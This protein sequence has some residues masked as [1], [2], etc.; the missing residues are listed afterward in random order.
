MKQENRRWTWLT[1]LYS[2]F[3]LVILG[4]TVLTLVGNPLKDTPTAPPSESEEEKYIYV[5]V[6][7]GE[8]STEAP[9]EESLWIVRE[10]EKKIGIFSEDGVLLDV[11]EVYTKTLPSAD[12][13]LLREGIFVRSRKELYSLMEDYGA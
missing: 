8:E 7:R 11:V 9:T 2:F 3:M 6:D 4:T 10:Y 12:R 5:Y 1:V 13:T